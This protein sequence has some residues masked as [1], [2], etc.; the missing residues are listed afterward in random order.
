MA[1]EK[2]PSLSAMS[3]R[4]VI[5]DNRIVNVTLHLKSYFVVIKECQF[6]S[7][8]AARKATVITWL[9][10]LLLESVRGPWPVGGA[11]L[12]CAILYNVIQQIKVKHI[13]K[14]IILLHSFLPS[15]VENDPS[16]CH[17]VLKN[18][19]IKEKINATENWQTNAKQRTVSCS[20]AI[21]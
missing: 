15:I 20:T 13:H 11:T 4:V 6:P 2:W 8:P 14:R 3:I 17:S 16:V 18:I 10:L 21:H 19:K 1:H 5:S 7:I 12:S 9:P